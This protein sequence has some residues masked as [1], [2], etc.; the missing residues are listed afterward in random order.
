MARAAPRTYPAELKAEFLRLVRE[1][2]IISTVAHEL[3]IHRPTAHV[4]ARK[5]GISTREA[6]QV[7]PRRDEFLRLR[8]AGLTRLEARTRVRASARSPT[9]RDK[10]STILNRGP[11]YPDARVVR[12][13]AKN[14][15]VVPK[16]R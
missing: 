5:A 3:G 9:G 13:P 11:V 15:T 7:T 1:R 14:N 8:A 16:T 6:R 2:Q 10:G 12:Y 4:W